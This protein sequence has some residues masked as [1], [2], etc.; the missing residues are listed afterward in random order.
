MMMIPITIATRRPRQSASQGAMGIAH[1]DPTDMMAFRRPRWGSEGWKSYPERSQLH[2]SLR[3]FWEILTMIFWESY[4][5][6]DLGTALGTALKLTV[7]PVLNS[8]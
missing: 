4:F 1:M 3:L 7:N 2:E 5:R 6:N 8:L